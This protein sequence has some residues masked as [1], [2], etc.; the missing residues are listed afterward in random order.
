M[1]EKRYVKICSNKKCTNR[2]NEAQELEC[3]ECGCDLVMVTMVE[4]TEELRKLVESGSYPLKAEPE[5]EQKV[6]T[7]EH[8]TKIVKICETC[9]YENL[10]QIDTCEQCGDYIGDIMP[11]NWAEEEIA[12]SEGNP[13]NHY[14]LISNM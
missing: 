14:E 3:V 7:P 2:I 9:G 8:V 10:P 5:P 13:V 1:G 12:I 11:V 6:I 4:Y